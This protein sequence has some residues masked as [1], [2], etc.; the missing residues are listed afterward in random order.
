MSEVKLGYIN[1]KKGF[2]EKSFDSWKEAAHPLQTLRKAGF[3]VVVKDNAGLRC[4]GTTV[5]KFI[6]ELVNSGR[7]TRMYGGSLSWS[8]FQTIC[9]CR[10]KIS[11]R[12]SDDSYGNDSVCKY[13]IINQ[14][15]EVT[16]IFW[17]YI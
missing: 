9:I 16:S 11:V 6:D 2:V 17:M 3:C 1:P 15:R 10:K 13:E 14:K 8:I 4:E 12:V 7:E 5:D